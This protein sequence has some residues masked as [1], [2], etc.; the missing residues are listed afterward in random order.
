MNAMAR[1]GTA[2][3]A[4]LLTCLAVLIPGTPPARADTEPILFV[5]GYG[6]NGGRWSTMIDRFEADG[7]PAD[8]L[9]T[10]DYDSTKSNAD[11]AADIRARVDAVRSATGAA[12]V[13]IVAMSMGSLNSRHYL[14]FLGGTAAVSTW[15]SLAGPNHGTTAT[16]FCPQ[17]R[18]TCQEMRAGSPFLTALNSGD[19]TPGDV[20]YGTFWSDCDT[21]V[22]PD[23]SVSLTGAV[24]TYAGCLSHAA[25]LTDASVYEKVRGFV[26]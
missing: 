15:V 9:F 20:A 17:D 10:I 16:R 22:N 13:T 26:S 14:K 25:F 5:H 4:A 7:W 8:R 24:N 2:L 12:K 23:S 18:P 21:V 19:E 1:A 11:I 3:T 6:G